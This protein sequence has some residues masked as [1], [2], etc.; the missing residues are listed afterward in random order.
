MN[1]IL[2]AEVLVWLQDPDFIQISLPRSLTGERELR[3]ARDR[4]RA[5][6]DKAMDWKNSHP[7]SL[8][9]EF[10]TS[11]ARLA[12][13]KVAAMELFQGMDGVISSVV[14]VSGPEVDPLFT[15]IAIR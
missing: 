6:I 14:Q 12:G 1:S 4:H 2:L 8:R 15:I 13:A 5:L 7:G 3:A 9:T 10:I 11:Q